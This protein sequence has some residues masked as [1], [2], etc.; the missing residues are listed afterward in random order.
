VLCVGIMRKLDMSEV[1]RIMLGVLLACLVTPIIIILIFRIIPPSLTPLMLIRY[2][3]GYGIAKEWVPLSR[4]STSAQR[5][6]I[7]SEDTKFCT[8]NG[9]DWEA[10]DKAIDRYQAKKRRPI[11]AS[12][13][14]M[15]TSKNLFLWPAR[16]FL[17]KAVEA[18]VTVLLET[19]MP[20]NRILEI[21]LNV[22][23]WGPGVY[24]IE[25][26][27]RKNFG[28]SA[29]Q[30][31]PSQAARLAAILPN[32]RRWRADM[33]GPGMRIRAENIRS[34]MNSVRLVRGGGCP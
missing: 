17:R 29:A 10:V 16:N 28:V 20:K 14:S 21:Y 23:E 3:E 12:T 26:A 11:G 5:A 30:L 19:F 13:I 18:Y 33:P 32:P 24:G 31:S 2:A 25:A 34:R 1:G 27:S 22:I 9:F 7:A 4:I 6:V 15:Q 8:H